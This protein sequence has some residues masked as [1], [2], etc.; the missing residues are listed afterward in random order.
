MHQRSPLLVAALALVNTGA[1]SGAHTNRGLLFGPT[2]DVPDQPPWSVYPSEGWCYSE[3]DEEVHY[4]HPESMEDP[5]KC[6]DVCKKHYPATITIDF[7]TDGCWCQDGCLCREDV[8][9]YDT[10]LPHNMEFDAVPSCNDFWAEVS[11]KGPQRHK[12]HHRRH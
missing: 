9:E 8:G 10:Y 5:M 12:R 11:A 7:S 4:N 2:P 6:F 3:L 1:V